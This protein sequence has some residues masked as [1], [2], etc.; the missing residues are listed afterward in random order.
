MI[1]VTN[2][3]G[4]DLNTACSGLAEARP[5]DGLSIERS[6]HTCILK[7]DGYRY[8]TSLAGIYRIKME[9]I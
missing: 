3:S 8:V 9:E 7:D 1:R 4:A 5:K 6:Q 2:L